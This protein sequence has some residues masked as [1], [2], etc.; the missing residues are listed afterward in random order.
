MKMVLV[1][2]L[3]FGAR[4]DSAFFDKF[5]ERFY[6][7]CFFPRIDE[8]GIK[9]VFILGDVF[10]RRK[11]IN[12]NILNQCKRYFFDELAKRNLDVHIL[13]GNHD[14]YFKNVNTV[15][16][17]DLLLK[18]YSNITAY[19]EPK[20]VEFDGLQLLAMPWICADNM[21]TSF[22]LLDK[23]MA[24]VCFGH[25]EIAGFQ[26]Y[27]GQANDHGLDKNIFDK[28]DLVCSG[29]FHHR[30]NVK[31]VH[32][33]GNPY[34]ITWAD[35]DDPRGF[36][37]FDTETLALQFIENPFRMF[38]KVY[39]DDT[40]K[41]EYDFNSLESKHVKIIVVN[42]TDFYSFDR[43]LD[44]VYK[45]S[46]LEVKIIEDFDQ[47]EEVAVD[48]DVNLED[49]VSLLGHYVDSVETDMDKDKIKMTLKGLYV[50]ALQADKE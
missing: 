37:I 40:K 26:M 34:E 42:K 7:D 47:F 9:T 43:F 24:P 25:F 38:V 14:V 5:F 22:E 30:S 3:H 33:L 10:D 13:V 32:Y 21:A 50:E 28:F 44:G 27:R 11:Y 49:T 8:E 41:Q 1:T 6:R 18:E 35:Y 17:I 45:A 29:H 20:H 31:Q 12:F 36:H 46:P 16:S 15:N 19:S 4:S 23:S 48:E 2:D 39:Y